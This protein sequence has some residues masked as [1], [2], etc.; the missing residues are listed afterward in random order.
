[1]I[2]IPFYEHFP[3]IADEETRSATVLNDPNLPN[4]SYDLV[5]AYC[6]DPDCD[7]RR[8]MFYIQSSKERQPM[9][10]VA[11]G[12]ESKRF[13]ANWLHDNDPKM[14]KELKGPSL[15][16]GSPQSKYAPALLRLVK[17]ILEDSDYVER[18]KRHYKMFKEHMKN[19]HDE[20]DLKQISPTRSQKVG[21]N[22]LCPCGSGKKYKKC[23][24]GKLIA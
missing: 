2:F 23:C 15:N 9:A 11:Y 19:D 14:I 1:M 21:R 16:V 5:E 10:V 18:L 7:C 4:A 13:Y 6:S 12:W 22:E 3:D 17:Q 20:S 8:V 24:L